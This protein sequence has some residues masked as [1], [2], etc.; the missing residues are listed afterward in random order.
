MD[1]DSDNINM[2]TFTTVTFTTVA[3]IK[4]TPS[5]LE[6]RPIDKRV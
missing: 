5:S 4:I 2:V 3:I 1:Y 6:L